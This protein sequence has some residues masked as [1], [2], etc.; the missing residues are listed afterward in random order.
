MKELLIAVGLENYPMFAGVIVACSI[1][2]WAGVFDG[3]V[4]LI[5]NT[6]IILAIS[7][8]MGVGVNMGVE[9]IMG[10]Q[11]VQWKDPVMLIAFLFSLTVFLCSLAE[12]VPEQTKVAKARLKKSA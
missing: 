5:V 2:F 9:R 12:I 10:M 11:I 3:S 6:S 8:V 1:V 7:T 4:R